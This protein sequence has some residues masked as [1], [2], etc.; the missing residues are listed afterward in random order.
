MLLLSSL[1]QPLRCAW[2][3]RVGVIVVAVTCWL[4]PSPAAAQN[5]KS[6]APLLEETRVWLNTEDGKVWHHVYGLT[7]SKGG[8]LLAFSEARTG[9]LDEEPHDI[10]C[11]RSTDGGKTWS[12][13]IPIERGDGSYWRANGQPGK[14][15][16]WTNTAP[17]AD[18]R[19]GRVFFFYA[20]NDGQVRGKNT[21]RM[22][23]VFYKVSD[24]EGKTWSERVDVTPIMN[25]KADG[26]PNVDASGKPV[27]N[28]DGF[29]CDHQ[30][31]A[32]HMPGP[33]HGIQLTNGR[34][35]LPVW[36]RL[37]IGNFREDGTFQLTR[38]PE[39]KYDVSM[40]ASDDGGKTWRT[41]SYVN[42]KNLVSESRLVE[43]AD[44]RVLHNARVDQPG[45]FRKDVFEGQGWHV[46]ASSHRFV[47]ISNDG[48]QRWQAGHFDTQLPA[49]YPTD[50]GL[51]RH[52]ARNKGE[53]DC[54][55]LSHPVSTDKRTGMTVS[56][57]FDEGKSWAHHRL[58]H[59]GG[60]GYSDLVRLPDGNV[61]LLYF[62]ANG[63]PGEDQ[64]AFA[65]LNYAWL[66]QPD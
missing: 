15:E 53:K 24:D 31:R 4:I 49:Y 56:V 61:G 42:Q 30:G 43:L 6:E 16:V 59:A 17:V 19:T 33:G 13:N 65:R 41:V 35:L 7:V 26:S 54:L 38:L 66:T 32:F 50:S 10:V 2:L 44:G 40:L 58:V 18:L 29:P 1:L 11:K 62:K 28:E 14:L 21:Q 57:S 34:L 20:L 46:P 27:L 8:S 64:V 39:R 47:S 9:K 36:H 48:G 37:P 5:R 3:V 51:L 63:T 52:K 23:R 22:T 60:T 12:A 45:E 55:L 25:V